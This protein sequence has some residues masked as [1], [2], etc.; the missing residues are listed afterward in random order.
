MSRTARRLVELALRKERLIAHA[1]AQRTAI[2]RNVARL[3]GPIAVADRVVSIGRFLRAHPVLIVVA[4]AA[5]VALRGRDLLS[6][7]GR[8]YSIW[9]LWRWARVWASRVFA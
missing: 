8:A 3:R 4:V 2:G 1:A 9:R 6:L 5:L 7:A